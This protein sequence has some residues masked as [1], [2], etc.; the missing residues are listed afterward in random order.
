MEGDKCMRLP[1]VGQKDD[2]SGKVMSGKSRGKREGLASAEER[3]ERICECTGRTGMLSR[4]CQAGDPSESADTDSFIE[5]A[6]DREGGDVRRVVV[7]QLKACVKWHPDR[8]QIA[9]RSHADRETHPDR[10][11][12]ASRSQRH[13]RPPA[14]RAMVETFPM[15]RFD[16]AILQEPNVYRTYEA[17]R[18]AADVPSNI[19]P[20]GS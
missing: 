8:T 19:L 4:N 20:L 9:R 2:R 14:V 11:Q 13:R 18:G 12:I 15:R 1:W 3:R 6:G 5:I 7:D 17:V 16:P 10:I